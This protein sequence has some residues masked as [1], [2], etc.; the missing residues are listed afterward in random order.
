MS[1]KVSHDDKGQAESRSLGVF[2]HEYLFGIL[3]RSLNMSW[4]QFPFLENEEDES[5]LIVLFVKILCVNQY[6]VLERMSALSKNYIW[7]LIL[8]CIYAWY[9]FSLANNL[10]P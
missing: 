3:R 5:Y 7:Y 9:N 4:P 10:L 2:S 6:Q 8:L 1:E